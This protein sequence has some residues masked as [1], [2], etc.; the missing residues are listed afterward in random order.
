MTLADSLTNT[1]Q[2]RKSVKAIMLAR[3]LLIC[4]AATIAPASFAQLVG[5][6]WA[7]AAAFGG[8]TSPAYC[9]AMANGNFAVLSTVQRGGR[10]D[11]V[12]SCF[13]PN[14]ATVWVKTIWSTDVFSPAGLFASANSDL[15]VAGTAGPSGGRWAYASRV[16]AGGATVWAK[17]H[18]LSAGAHNDVVVAAD[19]DGSNNLHL[20][21]SARRLISLAYDQP[22]YLRVNANGSRGITLFDAVPPNDS[23]GVAIRSNAS[24]RA[25]IA[26][27]TANSS[28]V[29]FVNSASGTIFVK[30]VAPIEDATSIDLTSTNLI[31]VGGRYYNS[32]LDSAPA[33]Q[34]LS[35]T[36]AHQWTRWV[37]FPYG[38]AALDVVTRLRVDATGNVWAVGS[39]FNHD[40]DFAVLKWNSAGSQLATRLM[41]SSATTSADVAANIEFGT[42]SDIYVAGSM[43]NAS[44]QGFMATRVNSNASFRWDRYLPVGGTMA[45]EFRNACFN[46]VTGQYLI[47]SHDPAGDRMLI[48]SLAQ[49]GI[50]QSDNYTISRNTTLNGSSVL[51]NDVYAKD[52]TAVEV[53]GPSHG[54]LTLNADGT[55]LYQPTA[56][57]FGI[58]NFT[59]KIA[60]PGVTDS[61]SIQVVITVT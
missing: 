30:N 16:S 47:V 20:T 38:G 37:N 50:P 60:K 43:T 26:I 36:G 6:T 32:A 61:A 51:N 44:N 35:A 21:G 11:G 4:L 2:H 13:R 18:K 14:G 5:L 27:Q 7:K 1:R 45:L 10:T 53:A 41:N 28:R 34:K 31:Y 17:R 46:T 24:G 54:T 40:L 8:D 19:L 52:G 56:G 12:L 23:A 3:L 59:Y 15:Y 9:A 29:W 55:F 22:V 48:H 39:A 25:A 57:Y 42:Q 33:I 49:P 58:D